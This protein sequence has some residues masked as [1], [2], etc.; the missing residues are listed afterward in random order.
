MI[1]SNH[2]LKINPILHR[3]GYN[4]NC[5][6]NT[7]EAI[8]EAMKLSCPIEI[9]V[10]VTKNNT[11]ILFHDNNLKRLFGIDKY[12]YDITNEDI[13]KLKYKNSNSK[14]ATL[15]EVLELVNGK[16]PLLIELK[17]N[18]DMCK[19][20]K[21]ANETSKILKNY[22]GEYAIQSFYPR[23]AKIYNR[24]DNKP[25]IGIL[26]SS[27]YCLLI[28]NIILKIVLKLYKYDFISY[29]IKRLPNKYLKQLNISKIYWTINSK[30]EEI[31]AIKNNGNFIWKNTKYK[32]PKEITHSLL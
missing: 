19:M 20:N 2:W 11:V 12:Y 18:K 4:N 7:I 10:R 16:V 9:D 32:A 28:N 17:Y 29:N 25:Y 22:K 14:I 21:L 23:M 27:K 30:Y 1:P 24:L 15:K 6:E 3:G 26:W 8:K 31:L 5:I 13:G